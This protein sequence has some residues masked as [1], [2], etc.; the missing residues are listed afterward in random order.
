MRILVADDDSF[1][2][3]VLTDALTGAGH[4]VIPA[5]S[6]SEALEKIV[7]E[8]PEMVILDVLMPGMA[9]T[10]VSEELSSEVSGT[11]QNSRPSSGMRRTT[12]SW[13]QEIR[14]LEPPSRQGSSS[15]TSRVCPPP[16]RTDFNRVKSPLPAIGS[17]PGTDEIQQSPL[18]AFPYIDH[19]TMMIE[20]PGCNP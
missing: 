14:T 4:E 18:Y 11:M 13:S 9:G 1:F 10:E 19:K 20:V 8:Q 15:R 12:G 3:Q 2:L 5:R 7:A 16:L 6:G 17:F